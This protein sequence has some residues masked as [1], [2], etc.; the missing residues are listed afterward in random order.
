MSPYLSIWVSLRAAAHKEIYKKCPWLAWISDDYFKKSFLLTTRCNRLKQEP[1]KWWAPVWS[2]GYHDIDHTEI[3][4][5]V[6]FTVLFFGPWVACVPG[7]PRG[8]LPYI[9]YSTAPSGGV[10]ARFWSE[11]G[12]TLCPFWSGIGHGFWGNYGMVWTSLSFQYQMSKK[13]RK[14]CEFQMDLKNFLFAL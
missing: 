11:N 2:S 1:I 12:Y 13:E 7:Y 3:S 8:V 5:R 10:F 6:S 9:S 14:I 4:L